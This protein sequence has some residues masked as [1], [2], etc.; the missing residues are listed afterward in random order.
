LLLVVE[1]VVVLVYKAKL[2]VS[3]VLMAVAAEELA[4]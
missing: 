2:L 1:A 3:A 4:V